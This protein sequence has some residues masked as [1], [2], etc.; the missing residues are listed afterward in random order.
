MYILLCIMSGRAV[1]D[2]LFPA[3][4]KAGKD[5]PAVFVCFPFW[6]ITGTMLVSWC[7]YILAVAVKKISG[8]RQPLLAA[9]IIAGLIFLGIVILSY[10]FKKS[11]KRTALPD[12]WEVSGADPDESGFRRFLKPAAYFL[13]LILCLI[14]V[15]RMMYHSF[16]IKGGNLEVGFSVFSD[17]AVH[18]GLIRSFS[19]GAN[20]PA[21]YVHFA[22]GDIRYHFL[23]QFMAGNLEYLGLPIHHAF[24]IPSVLSMM[25]A[26]MLLFVLGRQVSGSIAGGWLSVV[27]MLFRSSPSLFTYFAE[28]GTRDALKGRIDHFDYTDHESWG[29]WS[30]KVYLNQRHLAFGMA[31]CLM[32]VLVFLPLMRKKPG[33]F[34]KEAILPEDIARGVVMGILLGAAAFW[35]GAM[36]IGTL[37]VLF[38]MALMSDHRLEYLVTAVIAVVMS[39][40]QTKIFIHGSSF[41]PELYYGFLAE[42]RNIAG[43]IS[44]LLRL[45]G[46]LLPALLVYFCLAKGQK[47]QAMAAF[48]APL[49]FALHVSLTPDIA[50]NHKYIMLSL[51]LLGTAAAAMCVNLLKGRRIAAKLLGAG[52]ALIFTVT[53]MCEYNIN[54]NMDKYKMEYEMNDGLR[55]WVNKEAE[56]GAVWLSD[57]CSLNRLVLCGVRLYYGWPY[58]A[59]SAGYDTFAR[60]ETVVELFALRN[61]EALK[62]RL[63]DEGIRYVYVDGELRNS[64]TYDF[65]EETL[66]EALELVWQDEKAAV[67]E[68]KD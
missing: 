8:S 22:D 68:V 10:I 62:S 64:E 63:K 30:L 46:A 29:L 27:F 20:F 28:G 25:S 4:R 43:V 21:E 16:S 11:G 23:F 12:L 67:Y 5:L 50:V 13:P 52:L 18:L 26:L 41:S 40:L 38:V 35:N 51:V 34:K 31:L 56:P 61:P 54:R 15:I 6:Y 48:A 2:A 58:Y 44:F 24:N 32:A 14:F 17:F 42:H 9:N 3:Y 47:R 39:L 49:I 55:E 60:E 53:G 37:C 59:W 33:I 36:V 66:A 45:C 1:L 7:V 19:S 57:R 65:S